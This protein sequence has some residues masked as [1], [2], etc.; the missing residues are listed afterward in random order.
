M[1]WLRPLL[2]K[3]FAEEKPASDEPAPRPEPAVFSGLTRA[4]KRIRDTSRWIVA[5]FA[6]VA[7]V[8]IGTAPLDKVGDLDYGSGRFWAAA[9]GLGA[10]V[11][12]ITVVITCAAKVDAPV[13]ITTEQLKLAE[14]DPDRLTGPLGDDPD[15]VKSA[16][17]W[18]KSADLVDVRPLDTQT[19]PAPQPKHP[20]SHLLAERDKARD[21]LAVK[22][23]E[24]EAESDP[25]E[26]AAIRSASAGLKERFERLD[27][28]LDVVHAYANYHQLNRRF[29]RR[30]PWMIGGALAAALGILVF[31]YAVDVPDK[32]EAPPDLSG[33]SLQAASGVDFR[34][35]SLSGAQLRGADLREAN[36]ASS[37]LTA[38]N[39]AGADLTGAELS[40]ANLS[41]ADLTG[42]K[43]LKP[44]AVTG[45]T[46]V[47][48]TCPDG[49]KLTDADDT[50]AT[51]ARLA[52]R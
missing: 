35:G 1:K 45:A 48:A 5:S 20:I 52:P 14:T 11:M 46:W 19:R 39:L 44:E 8:V 3:L 41:A 24:A 31:K 30:K 28:E 23:A 12:A 6:A 9:L 26:R 10:V 21:Q 29:N 13:G 47:S 50:C 33:V 42:A 27:S 16:A 32:P 22:Q 18:I 51:E 49:T 34:G 40:N 43:G 36:L 25:T 17:N 38:A 2:E 37:D 15:G 4:T 7:A